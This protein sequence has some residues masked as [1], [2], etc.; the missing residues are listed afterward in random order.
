[1]SCENCNYTDIIMPIDYTQSA[2]EYVNRKQFHKWRMI[3]LQASH[4]FVFG[5]ISTDSS[6]ILRGIASGCKPIEE[7]NQHNHIIG[8]GVWYFRA[9]VDNGSGTINV[10]NPEFKE[11]GGEPGAELKDSEGNVI[12]EFNQ[13]GVSSAVYGIMGHAQS[14]GL[15]S[16][17]EY[18]G[19][20]GPADVQNNIQPSARQMEE[21]NLGTPFYR[22]WGLYQGNEFCACAG[23]FN[24]IW[25]MAIFIEQKELDLN[26]RW[27]GNYTS[28]MQYDPDEDCSRFK[29]LDEKENCLARNS[30]RPGR[31]TSWDHLGGGNRRKWNTCEALCYTD[32]QTTG[33]NVKCLDIN[34]A[35]FNTNDIIG[36][37]GN[38]PNYAP[39][40]PY[41]IRQG[42][43]V[44]LTSLP[45]CNHFEK[46]T[47]IKTNEIYNPETDSYDSIYTNFRCER[48]AIRIAG[49]CNSNVA[50]WPS[51]SISAQGISKLFHFATQ[52]YHYDRWDRD[53]SGGAYSENC[54][55]IFD[56]Q[57][58]VPELECG[59][60]VLAHK[61]EILENYYK[62]K[63]GFEKSTWMIKK[64]LT[65]GNENSSIYGN[66]G[67]ECTSDSG[68]NKPYPIRPYTS[69]NYCPNTFSCEKD[70]FFDGDKII[71]IEE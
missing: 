43:L 4:D 53:H 50:W 65:G 41:A 34:S 23:G 22:G 25:H 67:A 30:R 60:R 64:Y 6:G 10:P 15:V 59:I 49:F 9:K 58:Y 13:S 37:S 71:K 52:E 32:M 24:D 2:F 1:M 70:H 21:P 45:T 55:K 12:P 57:Y 31:F 29:T 68:E 69:F 42:I 27:T 35:V 14:P 33:D 26:G 8:R 18:I 39:L 19:G 63:T 46:V 66:R 61:K 44:K 28:V 38:G 16:N 11:K 56:E 3:G 47:P 51:C 54:F 36:G 5:K 48:A 17:R 40:L 20:V 7:I 62:E